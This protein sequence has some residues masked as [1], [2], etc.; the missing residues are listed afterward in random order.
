MM[1]KIPITRE[2]IRHFLRVAYHKRAIILLVMIFI[3]F[4]IYAGFLAFGPQSFSVL[5]YDQ[6]MKRQLE[7]NIQTLQEQNATLQK[8]LFEIKGLEP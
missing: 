7:D 3:T 1:K 6:A 5:S 8:K 2:N 4:S